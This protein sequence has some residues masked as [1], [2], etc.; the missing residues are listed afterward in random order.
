MVLMLVPFYRAAGK[1]V[2]SPSSVVHG[3]SSFVYY[4]EKLDDS[5]FSGLPK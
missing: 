2:I 1:I 5:V 3:K 4:G